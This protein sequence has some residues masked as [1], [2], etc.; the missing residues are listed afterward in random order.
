MEAIVDAYDSSER[1]MGV[2]R[3]CRPSVIGSTGWIAGTSCERL[4]ACYPTRVA[5]TYPTDKAF[6]WSGGRCRL[7]EH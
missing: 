3:P 7:F 1:A 5:L 4:E 2:K 6:A